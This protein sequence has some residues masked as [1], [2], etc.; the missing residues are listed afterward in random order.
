V[1]NELS[2]DSGAAYL[3]TNAGGAW[4]ATAYLK[5]LD[6]QAGSLFGNDVALSPDGSRIAIGSPTFNRTTAGA[7]GAVYAYSFV[8][9]DYARL[10]APPGRVSLGLGK[11][12]A[13]GESVLVAGAPQTGMG[14]GAVFLYSFR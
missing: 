12:I 13:L 3:F 1:R 9:D 4:R 5:A 8:R 10:D 11:S 2:R 6:T 7:E 14:V